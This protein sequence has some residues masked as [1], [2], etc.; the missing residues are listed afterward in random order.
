M[1]I[2]TP[3]KMTENGLRKE[4]KYKYF[5]AGEGTPI[6]ILHG[7]MGGLSNFGGVAEYFP[8][9]GALGMSLIGGVGMVGLS[10]FQPIIGGWLDEEKAKAVAMNI[11]KEAV[12]LA[13]GQATLD[14]I[15]VFPAILVVIF[16]ILFLLRK[17]LEA[18]KTADGIAN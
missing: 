11:P 18:L 9:T 13:A 7:L 10:L 16:G 14:N 8:K 12:E 15:A 6:I 5:E 3:N 4:G 2:D 17:K 1:K